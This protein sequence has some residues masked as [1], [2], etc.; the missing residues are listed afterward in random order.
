MLS[1]QDSPSRRPLGHMDNLYRRR[2]SMVTQAASLARV[3]VRKANHHRTPRGRRRVSTIDLFKDRRLLR[4]G[5]TQELWL[6]Y[7]NHRPT[8]SF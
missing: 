4:L 3:V 2:A 7:S 5:I 8:S 6:W 1:S